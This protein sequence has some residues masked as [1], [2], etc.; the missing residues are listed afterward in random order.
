MELSTPYFHRENDNSFPLNIPDTCRLRK[1]YHAAPNTAR[2]HISAKTFT[3]S[4]SIISNG[5]GSEIRSLFTAKIRA[6]LFR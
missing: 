4:L 6:F 2:F 1:F 3:A 5:Y